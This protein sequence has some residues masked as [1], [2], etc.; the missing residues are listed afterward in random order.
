MG[1]AGLR[2]AVPAGPVVEATSHDQ[3]GKKGRDDAGDPEPA[4]WPRAGRGNNYAAESHTTA[5]WVTV[6]SDA[7][8]ASVSSGTDQGGGV[9]HVEAAAERVEGL[10]DLVEQLLTQVRWQRGVVAVGLQLVKPLVPGVG[11]GPRK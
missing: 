9:G 2:H 4:H 3:D 5:A 8:E 6:V 11:A 1:L 10:A 7:A